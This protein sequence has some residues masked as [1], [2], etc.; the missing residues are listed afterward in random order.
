[1][2]HGTMSLKYTG[3]WSLMLRDNNGRP[4]PESKGRNY[5]TEEAFKISQQLDCLPYPRPFWTQ[6]CWTPIS[7]PQFM[8]TT[9]HEGNSPNASQ[10][11]TL[12][13]RKSTSD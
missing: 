3:S 8:Y 10:I 1:M 5:T 13:Y 11:L 9:I 12:S 6:S 7:C 4:I 2:M